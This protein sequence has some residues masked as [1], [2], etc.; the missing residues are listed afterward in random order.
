MAAQLGGLDTLD[1]WRAWKRHGRSFEGFAL[2]EP[3]DWIRSTLLWEQAKVRASARGAGRPA[4]RLRL[5]CDPAREQP[6][7]TPTVLAVRLEGGRVATLRLSLDLD[8][9]LDLAEKGAEPIP[10]ELGARLREQGLLS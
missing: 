3:G 5:A 8:R 9:V 2:G 1:L 7:T 4:E 10:A 6:N